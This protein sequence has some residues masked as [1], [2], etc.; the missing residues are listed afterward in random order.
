MMIRHVL[1]DEGLQILQGE[2]TILEIAR[3]VSALMR[4]KGIKGAIIGGVAVVLH[5]HVRTTIDVDVFVPEP[6]EPF[7]TLLQDNGFK[8]DPDRREFVKQGIAVHLVNLDQIK[9]PPK[10]LEEIEQI[11]TVSLADLINMKLR[12]G[13][14]NILRAQDL[15]DVIGLIRHRKLSSE[16]SPQIDEDARREYTRLVDA[17]EAD[18]S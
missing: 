9:N 5:G 4:A 3:E 8:F 18:D 13:S 6:L 16:F 1:R 10:K 11:T 2:G 14:G 17:I 7:S 15:A 12:S